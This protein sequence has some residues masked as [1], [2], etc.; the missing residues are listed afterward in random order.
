MK[1]IPEPS[2]Y[3]MSVYLED[4][5][6]EKAGELRDQLLRRFPRDNMVMRYSARYYQLT[7]GIEEAFSLLRKAILLH[8]GSAD[9]YELLGLFYRSIGETDKALTRLAGGRRGPTTSF[10]F[11]WPNTKTPPVPG[12]SQIC[13]FSYF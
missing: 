7:D 4:M 9:N 10:S 1:N 12:P 8:P 13:V 2:L 6:V 3:L 11:M 5:Q